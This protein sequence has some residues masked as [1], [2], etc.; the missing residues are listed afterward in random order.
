[1]AATFSRRE[2]LLSLAGASAL[3]LGRGHSGWAQ[4]GVAAK[5]IKE[6]TSRIAGVPKVKLVEVTLQPGAV[7]PT[8]KM[9]Q[10]MICEC[11]LGSLEVTQDDNRIVTMNQGDIWTCGVGT[12]EGVANKGNT[13]GIMRVFILVA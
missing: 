9:D 1:M 4:Q 13:A 6:T 3:L 7:M 12:M 10:A 2:V 5:E 8:T 11:T